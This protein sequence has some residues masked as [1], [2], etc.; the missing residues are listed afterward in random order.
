MTLR[1]DYLGHLQ[2]IPGLVFEEFSLKPMV[3]DRVRD[4]IEGPARVADLTV[5][6]ALVA[7]AMKDAATEDALP[8][9]AFT[10]RE[11]RDRF[12]G[13]RL[14]LANYQSMGDAAAG[15]TPLENS[16]RKRADE[17]LKQADPAAEELDALRQAFVPAMVRVNE[18][19]EYV[20]RPARWNELPAKAH[21]LLRRLADA[22]LLVIGQEADHAM[23]EVAHEALLRKWPRLRAWLD[24]QREFLMGKT[25]L[26]RSLADWER[27]APADKTAALLHGL[28]LSRAAQWLKRDCRSPLAANSVG[29]QRREFLP[30]T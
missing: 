1:S 20:R 19:G 7:A 16:L 4:I 8:L 22:R 24:Q 15:L 6:D 13:D 23:V 11:L 5:E 26:E 9:L 27:A 21:A 10:L 2:A 30:C 29:R 12:G 28:P 3:L 14:T 18:E 25:Q 17:V